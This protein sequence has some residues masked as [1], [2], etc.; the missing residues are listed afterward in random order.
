MLPGQTQLLIEN[1]I[2]GLALESSDGIL[3]ISLI[4]GLWTASLGIS[5]IIR[6][7]NKA[8][9]VDARRNFIRQKIISIIFTLILAILLILVLITLVFGEKLGN[10]VFSYIGATEVFYQT[11]AWLRKIIPMVFMIMI[12]GLLNKYSLMAKER[13]K[14]KFIHTLPGALFT[15]IGW[16]IASDLFSF[17]VNNFANYSKTYGALG[18]VI[19]LLVWLYITSVFIVLGGE[20]NGTFASLYFNDNR[21]R[22]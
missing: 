7:I 9:D 22:V 15:T 8:Y 4:F 1:F 20:I 2:N 3:S 21:P 17:Y 19:V 18:G 5:A 13:K 6:A 11:W 16:I 10:M 14:I 12:F